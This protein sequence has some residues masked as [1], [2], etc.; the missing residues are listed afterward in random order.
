[1][2]IFLW[3]LSA[4]F[5]SIWSSFRKKA[6]DYSNLPT[7]LFSILWPIMWG[8][9]IWICAYIFWLQKW[10]YA[11]YVIIFLILLVVIFETL[12]NYIEIYVFKHSKLSELLPYQNANK[13]LIVL[14]W[15]FLYYWTNNSTSITSFLIILFT[16]FLL[17]FTSIDIKKIKINK[18][19]W[20]YL[21][22]KLFSAISWLLIWYILLKYDTI[23]YMSINLLFVFIIY[24][25]IT[26]FKKDR[27]NE[28][29]K[30]KKRIL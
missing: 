5:W 25:L 4:L 19:I 20:I 7:N 21:I 24:Y 29:L 16:I 12:A 3:I 13:L 27:F 11:N 17:I 1:M 2:G 14:I 15:F 9:I 28:L 22:D 8:F 30:Q 10:I 26:I 23:S 6:V 18:M